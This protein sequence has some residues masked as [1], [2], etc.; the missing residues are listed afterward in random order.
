[1]GELGS[2]LDEYRRAVSDFR[3]EVPETFNF[4]RD[5]VDRLAEDPTRPA[6]LWRDGAGAS[7]R[8]GFA[9]VRNHLSTERMRK[10]L[11]TDLF[12]WHG[13]TSIHL[14][15]RWVK[16][17]PAF[18]VELCEKFSLL[19]LEFDGRED[20]IYHPFDL[21]GN[22]HMEY[23]NERGEFTDVP[24]AAIRESFASVYPGLYDLEDAD[25]DEDVA[26]ET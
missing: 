1:M 13:Y 5:V 10:Q 3:W 18:N 7:R 19:P 15:G 20:S 23:V 26:R 25:F 8:L 11:K 22:R 6:L 24:I 17:T 2:S 21:T 12:V 14:D 9:D 16:A 4:G